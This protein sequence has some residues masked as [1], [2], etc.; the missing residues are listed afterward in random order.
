IKMFFH[1]I[2]FVF[3]AAPPKVY[4]FA[5]KSLR[6]PRMLTLTCLA[7][8]FYPKDVVMRVR[9]FGT[10]FPEHLITSSAVRP[11]DDGTF[12]LRKSV[13]IQEDDKAQFD[14]CVNHIT[15][16]KPIIVQWGIYIFL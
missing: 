15:L 7:T 9:K 2:L 6:D 16:T 4:A 11:N 1:F 8:G 14:C 10:S 13:E 5:K 3:A 12:Q